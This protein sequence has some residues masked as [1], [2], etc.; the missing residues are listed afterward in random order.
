MVYLSGENRY[1]SM[2]VIRFLKYLALMEIL[3]MTLTGNSEST[4]SRLCNLTIE[5]PHD[6]LIN[7]N[8]SK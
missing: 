7:G 5:V 1:E 8:Y 2:K 4:M 6:E 3:S